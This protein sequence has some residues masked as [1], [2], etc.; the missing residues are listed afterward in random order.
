MPYA[1]VVKA[2]LIP[3]VLYFGSVFW[4]VHLEAGKRG[5]VGMP[6]AELPSRAG[7]R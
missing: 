3:A 5:L 1:D 2:A 6:K 4:M 7:A